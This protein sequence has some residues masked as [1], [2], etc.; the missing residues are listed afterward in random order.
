M[1][2]LFQTSFL[3]ASLGLASL[4]NALWAQT[5]ALCA[6]GECAPVISKTT[7]F[8]RPAYKLTD[9]KTEA[10]IVPQI[11]RIMRFGKVGGPNLLWNSP[12]PQG[13][14]WKWKN[15]GGDKNWLA[16]QSNWK[17]LHGHNWP[18]DPDLDGKPHQAEVISGGKLK[19]TSGL[20][21]TGICMVRIM[22]FDTKGEFVIEQTA[23]KQRGLT[24]RAAIWNISQ[25][26]PGEAFFL[27][28]NSNS[29]YEN[30]VFALEKWSETQ[31]IEKVN[32]R[33]VRIVP[34]IAGGNGK[35]GV[36]SP[37]SSLVSVRDGVAFLQKAPKPAGQYPDGANGAGFPVELYI[38]GGAKTYYAE[39]E[40]LG[41]LRDF[42]LGSKST[43][44]M[45]WSLHDLP[46]KDV[47]SPAVVEAVEKLLWN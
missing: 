43:H 31:K 19:M 41:P 18:P 27:P 34:S 30:G 35:I 23:L 26:V 42:A 15:Y 8:A 45:R 39:M 21:A 12:T 47:A 2:F 9:G 33:I 14:D 24:V 20:S 13:I 7:Y 28:L 4:Q 10:I 3:V 40:L 44:T 37:V 25:V 46:S 36:D 17:A 11:G 22:S 16:P 32:P 29:S 5:S 6:D 38:F 1:K